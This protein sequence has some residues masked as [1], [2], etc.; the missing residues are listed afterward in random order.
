M[1]KSVHSIETLIYRARKALK[2]Q[3]KKGGFIYEEL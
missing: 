1:K 3:L 2:S